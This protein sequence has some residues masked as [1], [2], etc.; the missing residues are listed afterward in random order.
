VAAA[1]GRK[2][3]S[4]ERGG[5]QRAAG[6]GKVLGLGLRYPRTSASRISLM[7][8]KVAVSF[9]VG[10]GLR[11]GS[12]SRWNATPPALCRQFLSTSR[13]KL[14]PSGTTSASVVHSPSRS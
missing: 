7:V 2:A 11:R 4:Y 9:G 5:G 12:D 14:R 13:F 6:L 1:D 3:P 10:G 8:P